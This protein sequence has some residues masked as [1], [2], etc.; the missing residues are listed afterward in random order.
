MDLYEYQA[1][2]LLEEQD[3]PTPDA[4]FAQN[5]HEVAEAADKI[6]YPCVIKAQ[7][8]IGH[9]GQAGGVKIA[10][11]RD[12]AILESESILPM[13]IHGH[14]VS[15]VLVAEAKNILHEYYVSCL[16]YTSPSPRDA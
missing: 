8:K 13:T 2:Q 4:I 11:N 7:V 3:I 15:G 6:G 14:K 12:E 5:S 16:L 9:R 1:R 10:H